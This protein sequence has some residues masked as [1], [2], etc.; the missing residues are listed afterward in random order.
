MSS[1]SISARKAAFSTF[2]LWR[3]KHQREF[4]KSARQ[5]YIKNADE[6]RSRDGHYG[7]YDMKQNEHW[8]VFTRENILRT[9][10]AT[11]VTTDSNK[12]SLAPLTYEEKVII[13]NT[14]EECN[15]KADSIYNDLV[16]NK[17]II[18]YIQYRDKYFQTSL[19]CWTWALGGNLKNLK[20]APAHIS[21]IGGNPAVYNDEE[22]GLGKKILV[23]PLVGLYRYFSIVLP[24]YT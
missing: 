17:K 2:N 7:K 15:A 24:L 9:R 11:P 20:D 8:D 18:E 13:F 1:V 10:H 5:F 3:L 12:K 21:K 16:K 14:V 6:S 19:P 4:W 22:S 23:S